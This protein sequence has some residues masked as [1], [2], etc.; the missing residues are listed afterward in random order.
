MTDR[1]P[2]ITDRLT[3][4]WLTWFAVYMATGAYGM[5]QRRTSFFASTV[6]HV[7]WIWVKLLLLNI[8]LQIVLALT[9]IQLNNSRNVRARSLSTVVA[10][11]V[12]TLIATHIV[13]S[14]A[15]HLS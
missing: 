1:L 14:I 2:S 13:L 4:V 3:K 10:V 11:V 6:D 5:M 9:A 15:V 8:P 12:T 7:Q